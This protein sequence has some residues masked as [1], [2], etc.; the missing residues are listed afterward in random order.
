MDK[1][2]TATRHQPLRLLLATAQDDCAED[3]AQFAAVF[4]GI[5]ACPGSQGRKGADTR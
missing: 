4:D 1:L 3:I 5:S 2:F